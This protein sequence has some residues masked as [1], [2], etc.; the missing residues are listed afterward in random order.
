[1]R[2]YLYQRTRIVDGKR[3][4]ASR[5]WHYEIAFVSPL[6]G[7][8]RID[9]G[10]TGCG[11]RKAAER[12]LDRRAQELEQRDLRG[13]P[14]DQTPPLML[15]DACVRWMEEVGASRKTAFDIR[16]DLADLCG[17]LG[18]Q[19]ALKNIGNNE[20]LSAVRERAGQPK[21][22]YIGKDRAGKR[23][24]KAGALPSP[25]TINR[26]VVE[27][28]R[29]VMLRARDVWY[30]PIP[31]MPVWKNLRKEEPEGRTREAMG[32]EPERYLLAL[33]EDY[34]PFALFYMGS[35]RR[36]REVLGMRPELID[37]KQR[38]YRYQAK[39][40]RRYV[41]KTATLTDFEVALLT[42]E[43]AKAPEGAV[44]SYEIATGR[45][46]GQ[47]AA[48]TYAGFRQH[49]ERAK[50]NAGIS[51][52]RRHDWRHDA[53]TKLVRETGN[54]ALAKE[55]AGHADISS[56]M[57]YVH[58]TEADVRTARSGLQTRNLPALAT[59]KAE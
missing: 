8:R 26:Q 49:D 33:R 57:R 53:L 42:T 17:L 2:K 37:L 41:W 11:E 20:V 58:A 22:V 29:R 35:S 4:P 27:P 56:T 18:E 13:E 6:S 19:T 15:G 1:M 10:S 44:W 3:V 59:R 7:E 47:R 51:D 48:I 50:L 54:L 28:L 34:R 40:K 38:L 30:E 12:W 23:R 45:R 9:R 31:K 55:A 39:H 36:I 5:F 25:G 46:K 52:F 14:L 24:Y 21:R 32:D 16:R 43:L